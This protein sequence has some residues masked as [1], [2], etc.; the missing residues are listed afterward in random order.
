[1]LRHHRNLKKINVQKNN[2]LSKKTTLLL[3]DN[4]IVSKFREAFENATASAAQT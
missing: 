4:Q 1:V 3:T 2:A